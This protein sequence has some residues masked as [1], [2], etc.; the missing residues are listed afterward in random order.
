[1]SPAERRR[2]AAFRFDV[3]RMRFIEAHAFLRAIVAR[4]LGVDPAAV[5]LSQRCP[6]CN[7]EHGRPILVT[8]GGDHDKRLSLSLAHSSELA[9]V[10]VSRSRAVGVDVEHLAT[11]RASGEIAGLALTRRE[12]RAL[13][14]AAPAARRLC[15]LTLWTRKEAILK[16]SPPELQSLERIDTGEHVPPVTGGAAR[17]QRIDGWDV[18]S[19]LIGDAV[20]SVAGHD[21]AE[22]RLLPA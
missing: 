18:A 20:I 6:Y 15:F 10:A 5:S 17:L 1:L 14:N 13:E 16:A 19:W 3:H 11:A 21:L 12:R 7:R 4:Y 2:A 9:G 8:P 22:A